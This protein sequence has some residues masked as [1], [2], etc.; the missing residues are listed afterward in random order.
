MTTYTL[1]YDENGGSGEMESQTVN[2]G[3]SVTVKSNAFTAPT[4]YSFK[5]W[6]TNA[7]GSGTKYNAGQSVTMNADLTLYAVWSPKSYTVTLNA[8]GGTGGTTSVQAVFDEPMPN[9]TIPSRSGYTF[10][11]YYDTA[12]KQYY[13][14]NGSSCNSWITPSNAT[15]TAAWEEKGSEP[16]VTGDLHFWF[17]YPADAT[18]NGVSNDGTVFTDMYSSTSSQAGSITIDGK[19]YTIT[20]RSGDTS[21]FGTFT[22][23]TGKSAIFYALA[24]SSGGSSRQI[25]LIS[26]TDKYELSVPGGSS[27]YQRLESEPLPAGTYSVERAASSGNVRLA[28]IVLKFTNEGGATGMESAL[29]SADSA[30]KIIREGQLLILR[31]GKIYTITG[32]SL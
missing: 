22:I 8:N 1:E 26:S 17:F 28:V 30:Q 2:E 3:A 6:N 12:G 20:K 29:P 11:G 23:P 24:V 16:V 15:L 18:A 5:E 9:I 25:D 13:D 19:S 10:T 21:Q 27:T 32:Q 14:A 31:D 7:K 4:G